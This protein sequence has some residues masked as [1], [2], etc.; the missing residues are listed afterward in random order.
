MQHRYRHANAGVTL[1]S[2]ADSLPGGVGP[3]IAR[4]MRARGIALL[5][6]Q[7]A[8]KVTAGGVQLALGAMVDAD[9]VVAATGA[10]AAKWPR[11][12]GLLTDK[13]GFI[14]VNDR[15]QSVSHANV[16]A[17]GDCATIEH[18]PRPKSGVYAVRA[19]PPLN[20]NLRRALRGD[21]LKPYA[22]QRRS[23]YLLSAGNKYAIGSWG[24]MAWEGR[25]VWWW[26]D[27]IDRTFVGKYAMGESGK[28]R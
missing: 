14:L 25:W 26:K 9:F 21:A 22:P 8:V 3:R 27:M 16:F 15:L 28:E 17:V 23:L 10:S 13:D 6:G 12:S 11:A 1:V 19:G 2:A 7:A 20:E 18:H 5:A 4:I 24:K